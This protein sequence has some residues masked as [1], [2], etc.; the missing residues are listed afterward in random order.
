MRKDFYTAI[1]HNEPISEVYNRLSEILNKAY[2]KERA[3]LLRDRDI[4]AR[5]LDALHE[6]PDSEPYLWAFAYL[7]E[8][9]KLEASKTEET[10]QREE[11]RRSIEAEYLQMK[12]AELEEMRSRHSEK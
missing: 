6:N 10:L 1:L 5:V 4:A 12:Q 11:R 7:K 3:A 2:Q 9:Q 8:A